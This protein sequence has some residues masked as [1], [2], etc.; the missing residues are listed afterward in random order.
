MICLMPFPPNLQSVAAGGEEN[1]FHVYLRERE[2]EKRQGLKEPDRVKSTSANGRYTLLSL[3]PD[4]LYL[5][6]C[7]C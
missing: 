5:C 7:C 1:Y 4:A 6:C 3:M 2:K